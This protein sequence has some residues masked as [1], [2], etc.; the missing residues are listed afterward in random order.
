MNERWPADDAEKL[1]DEIGRDGSFSTGANLSRAA[2]IIRRFVGKGVQQ[3]R[4]ACAKRAEDE[5]EPQLNQ[6]HEL[7]PGAAL[8]DLEEEHQIAIA[9]VRATKFR[10]AAA[11]RARGD[12]A[13]TVDREREWLRRLLRWCRPRLKHASYQTWLDQYLAAGPSDAPV[14]EPPI[15]QSDDAARPAEPPGTGGE[16]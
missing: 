9:G 5:E 4:E 11:I 6:L 7:W 8:S 10:I 13:Q 15:V 1:V 2:A 3:E 16:G 14:D 12:A